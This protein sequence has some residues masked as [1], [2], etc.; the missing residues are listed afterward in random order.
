MDPR[1]L[2]K[3]I[4]DFNKTAFDNTFN[5]LEILMEQTEKAGSMFLDQ[6]PLFPPE[7]KKIVNEWVRIY[8]KEVDDFKAAVD[9]GYKNAYAL[10]DNLGK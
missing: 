5:G 7:G 1:E 3:Q 4:I 8:K 2:A 6:N 9:E 10:L